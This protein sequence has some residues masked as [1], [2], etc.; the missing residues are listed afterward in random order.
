MSRIKLSMLLIFILFFTSCSFKSGE[1]AIPTSEDTFGRRTT[2]SSPQSTDRDGD[3]YNVLEEHALGTSDLIADVPHIKIESANYLSLKVFSVDKKES[4]FEILGQSSRG[5]ILKNWSH[6][7]HIADYFAYNFIFKGVD[8]ENSSI[9]YYNTFKISDFSFFSVQDFIYKTRNADIYSDSGVIHFKGTLRLDNVEHLSILQNL[10]FSLITMDK[11][12]LD[13]TEIGK[14]IIARDINGNPLVIKTNDSVIFNV[15]LVFNDLPS[16]RIIDSIIKGDP[17]LIK[18][19]ESN[20]TDKMNKTYSLSDQFESSKGKCYAFISIIDDISN[21]KVISS[22]TKLNKA[23]ELLKLKTKITYDSL[24]NIIRLGE[25]TNNVQFPVIE[26]ELALEDYFKGNVVLSGVRPNKINKLNPGTMGILKYS[27][28]GNSKNSY[29][30]NLTVISD[31]SS[32]IINIKNIRAGDLYRVEIDVT[33]TE[34]YKSTYHQYTIPGEV[35]V[36][37]RSCTGPP[38]DRD[39]DPA[40]YRAVKCTWNWT[41]ALSMTK[42]IDLYSVGDSRHISSTVND[43]IISLDDLTNKNIYFREQTIIYEILV[44]K[45]LSL[46]GED[47]RIKL[48]TQSDVLGHFNTGFSNY[49]SCPNGNYWGRAQGAQVHPVRSNEIRRMYNYKIKVSKMTE[50]EQ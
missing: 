29:R 28:I 10:T 47:I 24:G 32:N 44:T 40:E 8:T 9:D 3:L 7:N 38:G 49:T 14:P 45:T 23:I 30:N 5:S 39:C 4:K 2:T 50:T 6:Y 17:F 12:S 19:S 31:T 25:A 13:I 16:S 27:T 36:S 41:S 35:M 11:N 33:T 37:P 42:S 43:N 22:E 15:D 18:L 1:E 48:P 20:L 34:N 46:Q 21:S 26:D